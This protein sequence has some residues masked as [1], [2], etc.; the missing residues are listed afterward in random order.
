MQNI[1]N[2]LLDA[3][4]N[5][6]GLKMKKSKVHSEQSPGMFSYIE[7]IQTINKS[8][9]ITANDTTVGEINI[10][11]NNRK[12]GHCEV[13]V[14]D[15]SGTSVF[16][17]SRLNK[18][19]NF[20]TDMGYTVTKTTEFP[21]PFPSYTLNTTEHSALY[22]QYM[23]ASGKKQLACL[24]FAPFTFGL[25][26]IPCAY[27]AKMHPP[28]AKFM[29]DYI[30]TGKPFS[31]KSIEFTGTKKNKINGRLTV[32]ESYAAFVLYVISV[33]DV[34]TLEIVRNSPGGG[35]GGF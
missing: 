30:P 18:D 15:M 8:I 19:A 29:Y 17:A 10:V 3:I 33:A 4:K 20:V 32:D 6:D 24:F 2:N 9:Y 31:T 21:I 13:S 27:Y 1:S 14:L 35:G 26:L 7:R 34:N 11:S 23:D 12:L 16:S 22:R 5:E 28:R 25:S